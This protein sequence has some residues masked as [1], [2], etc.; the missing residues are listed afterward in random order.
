MSATPYPT[1][2][3][4]TPPPYHPTPTGRQVLLT[5]HTCPAY[6]LAWGANIMLAGPD[7]HV[8]VLSEA[9]RILQQFN[10]SGD[11]GEREPTVATAAPGGQ[12]VVIGSYDR[13]TEWFGLRG[14]TYHQTPPP[15]LSACGCTTTQRGTRRGSVSRQW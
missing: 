13:C 3:T 15:L 9:G 6:A 1:S 4:P 12:S 10:H 8:M 2:R 11:A 5:T 7:R 14:V